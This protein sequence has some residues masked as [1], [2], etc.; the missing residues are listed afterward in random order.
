MLH[1]FL[2]PIYNNFLLPLDYFLSILN[3]L[4]QSIF[5]NFFSNLSIL[6][7][8]PSEANLLLNCTNIL[9]YSSSKSLKYL[10][11][12]MPLA[13]D[14]NYSNYSFVKIKGD[15][16]RLSNFVY[17]GISF[18]LTCA[19]CTVLVQFYN[20]KNN[21]KKVRA[22]LT[23]AKNAPSLN[24]ENRSAKLDLDKLQVARTVLAVLIMLAKEKLKTNKASKKITEKD[25]KI[26]EAN[27]I[28]K[29][30]SEQIYNSFAQIA[31]PV[32]KDKGKDKRFPGSDIVVFKDYCDWRS[33]INLKTVIECLSWFTAFDQKANTQVYTAVK[34]G[35]N[36][37]KAKDLKEV[38][39][40]RAKFQKD[41]IKETISQLG[42]KFKPIA[43]FFNGIDPVDLINSKNRKWFVINLGPKIFNLLSPFFQVNA[44]FNSFTPMV[45]SQCFIKAFLELLTMDQLT[46]KKYHSLKAS[47][48][49]GLNSLTGANAVKDP[50]A[51]AVVDT[52]SVAGSDGPCT[53]PGSNVYSSEPSSLRK[54]L[55][56]KKNQRV[57]PNLDLESILSGDRVTGDSVTSLKE[58][59]AP[60][61][62]I[63]GVSEIW[64]LDLLKF[65]KNY[66]YFVEFLKIKSFKTPQDSLIN[67]AGFIWARAFA[68]FPF[69]EFFSN[70]PEHLW[71]NIIE[72]KLKLSSGL[73]KVE[74]N[75][76]TNLLELCKFNIIDLLSING[77]ISLK[78]LK[79]EVLKR[80]VKEAL[81]RIDK[82]LFDYTKF[83]SQICIILITK[84]IMDLIIAKAIIHGTWAQWVIDS[85]KGASQLAIDPTEVSSKVDTKNIDLLVLQWG[86]N[87]L[88]HID[89]QDSAMAFLDG[90][91]SCKNLGSSN[92]DFSNPADLKY[93][94]KSKT[95]TGLPVQSTTLTD[96]P[97]Q[98]LKALKDNSES[99]IKVKKLGA[100]KFWAD[101]TSYMPQNSRNYLFIFL[102]LYL[103][104]VFSLYFYVN[105]TIKI[106]PLVC[107]ILVDPEISVASAPLFCYFK[108]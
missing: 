108:L 44:S 40:E 15:A 85:A 77:S 79:K 13:Y 2:D 50:G 4:G 95:L 58:N 101:T 93:C 107:I 48:N 9:N 26:T 6:S 62:D 76:P 91:Y 71:F 7:I 35:F 102:L 42:F 60:E 25:K 78:E 83:S 92:G 99:A 72:G 33:E 94:F 74:K 98:I 96:L 21:L 104:V 37:N 11:L 49:E 80:E 75:L 54:Y 38:Q 86:L 47:Q 5:N 10:D 46:E 23:E 56:A 32:N 1:S 55:N 18:I 87:Y 69:L 41:F 28:V 31:E 43:N 67:T 84:K 30:I 63:N 65:A 51:A 88:I 27:E 20:T 45:Y 73:V 34:T 17:F 97:V 39:A 106:N 8:A 36:L 59:T 68:K 12:T 24:L 82:K 90:N 19:F 16:Q 105:T 66:A 103:I 29:R 81:A 64:H 100:L 22:K 3:I 61:K 57:K 52:L 89:R 70:R 14:S 53:G